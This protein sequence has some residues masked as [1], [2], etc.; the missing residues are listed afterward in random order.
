MRSR[1]SEV[2]IDNADD[3]AQQQGAQSQP[4]SRASAGQGRQA[5]SLPFMDLGR[6]RQPAAMS[7]RRA[8]A[9]EA[10]TPRP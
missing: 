5:S 3:M 9:A 1:R 10:G 4:L 2:R 8:A 7:F 6:T